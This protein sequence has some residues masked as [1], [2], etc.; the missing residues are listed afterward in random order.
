MFCVFVCAMLQA[1]IMVLVTSQTPNFPKFSP[2]LQLNIGNTK[3]AVLPQEQPFSCR[4]IFRLREDLCPMG[5]HYSA[6][7][8]GPASLWM[9]PRLSNRLWTI[10]P[11][12]TSTWITLNWLLYTPLHIHIHIH[13]HELTLLRTKKMQ[14]PQVLNTPTIISGTDGWRSRTTA[15]DLLAK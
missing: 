15:P 7:K 2:V 1:T 8:S 11:Q 13:H 9:T 10:S 4:K 12:N 6:V 5:T 3:F 14:E